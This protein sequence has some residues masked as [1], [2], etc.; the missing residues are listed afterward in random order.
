MK[1]RLKKTFAAIPLL[2]ITAGVLIA[3]FLLRADAALVQSQLSQ[4][5]QVSQLSGDDVISHLNLLI[6]WYRDLTTNVQAT[7]LPIDTVYRENA[8]RLAFEAVQLGFQS[9]EEE[10]KLVSS[11][12]KSSSSGNPQ[13]SGTSENVARVQAHIAA[14][15]KQIA[16]LTQQIASATPR[17]KK[18]LTEQRESLQGQLGLSQAVLNALQQLVDFSETTGSATGTGLLANIKKLAQSIPD[19]LGKPQ[20][21]G[22]A[23]GQATTSGQNAALEQTTAARTAQAKSSSND[24]KAAGGGLAAQAFALYSVVK[25]LHQLDLLTNETDNVR[26]AAAQVRKPLRDALRAIAQQGGLASTI[27]SSGDAAASSS[28]AAATA[29]AAAEVIN[30]LTGRASEQSAAPAKQ[31]APAPKAAPAAPAAPAPPPVDYAALTQ[32]FNELSSAALPVSQEILLLDQSKSNLYEWRRTIVSESATSFRALAFHIGLIVLALGLVLILSEVWRRFTFRYIKDARRRRQFLVVRRFVIGFLM[33]VV[34]IL[35]FVSQFSSLVTFAGFVTAG[36][37]VGLQ[38]V[39]LSVAAYFFLIGRWGIRVGDRVSVSGVTGDVI[40]VGLVRFY[41]M[42]LSGTGIDLYQTGRIVVFANSVL[43]QSATP[44]FKQIPGTEYAWHEVAV[45]VSPNANFPMVQEWLTKSVN[46]V[47]QRYRGEIE[48]QIEAI[49]ERVDMR[50]TVPATEARLQFA[51]G[52]IE[53]L[54]RYPVEIRRSADIDEEI[55]RAVLDSMGKD[56]TVKSAVTG[57]PK[58]RAVV[59]G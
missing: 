31:P 20:A 10:A 17:N 1:S 41:M 18:A 32:Q 39:L 58:I 3:L 19:V 49:E 11:T 29:S 37:A 55:T 14:L 7:G 21:P 23:P 51:D 54:V 25:A 26:A 43:F 57:L 22:G 42:E 15:Q 9:A 52:G 53:L 36:I 38:A 40:D 5:G 56:G 33:G 46:D 2:V 27:S 12:D 30:K 28:T 16:A 24:L 48:R 8:Q 4:S 35:G 50:L 45:Q 44:L 47:Y 13:G 34:L 59:R 6:A